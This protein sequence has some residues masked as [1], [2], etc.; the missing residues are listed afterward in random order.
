VDISEL[1]TRT[2]VLAL[3]C[4]VVVALA[5]ST[6]GSTT[7]ESESGL[8]S[9]GPGGEGERVSD[10]EQTSADAGQNGSSNSLLPLGGQRGPILTV[11]VTWLKQPT[12]QLGLIAGLLGLFAVLT[13]VRDLAEGLAFSTLVGYFGILVYYFL[14]SCNTRTGDGLGAESGAQ[15]PPGGGLVGGSPDVTSPSFSVQ[16]LLFTVVGLFLVAAVVVL[17]SDHDLTSRT[18]TADDEETEDPEMADL[19]AI[20]VA[21]GDAAD[22]IEYEDQFENDIYRAWAEMTED[23]TVARPESS[24]PGEFATAAVEAG[25]DRDDVDRL[26]D[27]FTGV[28]YGDQPVTEER[29]A[30]AVETLRRIESRY[31][32]EES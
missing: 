31:A 26:T 21:A 5:A 22:R 17:T 19:E 15:S 20:G 25:M 1:N 10:G 28:R 18:V 16:L 3:L 8:G 12:V 6:L 23:L 11:C 30:A 29:E 7:N 4:L 27:L 32:G 13:Y 24:T 9:L 14:T 2:L